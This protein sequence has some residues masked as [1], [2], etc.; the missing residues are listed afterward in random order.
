MLLLIPL[1]LVA[2]IAASSPQAAAVVVR[3]TPEVGWL[4]RVLPAPP[5]VR[6]VEATPGDASQTGALYVPHGQGQWPGVLLVN[7][8]E[9]PGG[10][11]SP[12]VETFARSIADLGLAVYVPD[13]PGFEGG[14]LT[15]QALDALRQDLTWFSQSP[16]VR[17]RRVS[18][19]GVCVG[20]SLGIVL[21]EQPG[22]S[23]NVHSVVAIDPYSSIRNSVQAATTGQAPGR[24]GGLQ[25][26]QMEPWVR[27]AMV[28]SLGST[29]TD[30]PSRAAVLRALAASPEDDP[31]RA[32][33]SAPPE[34]LS[35][36]ATAW[37]RLL[38]NRDPAQFEALYAAQPAQ[39]RDDLE[40]LSPASNISELS[41]P[42][43]I[44][45]PY[46]DFAFPPGDAGELQRGN[47]EY[48]RLTR[49]SAL[50]HVTPTVSPLVLRDYWELWRFAAS[51]I[52]AL[53]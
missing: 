16:H 23:H 51:G 6:S 1:A 49:T 22:T 14:S 53:R 36:A 3:N 21:A 12:E 45:A 40:M 15:L 39:V 2:V 4:A 10:W 46:H 47:P 24:E 33:Q 7:G 31:L 34:G 44:A 42:V 48:V 25:S 13:L 43:L 30:Q 32:F 11:R 26:F 17:D 28:R 35:P 38:G 19:V 29:I 18:L 37:W 41:V 50:D 9:V 52:A 8:A 20:G 5:L 27:A